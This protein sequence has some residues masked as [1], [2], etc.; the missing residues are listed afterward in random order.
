MQAE[1]VVDAGRPA[2]E[3]ADDDQVRQLRVA[4]AAAAEAALAVGRVALAGTRA[5]RLVGGVGTDSGGR[6][7]VLGLRHERASVTAMHV[8]RSR[9]QRQLI[10]QRR[11][12]LLRP[13]LRSPL[14]PLRDRARLPA[15][16]AAGRAPGPGATCCAPPTRTSGSPSCRSAPPTSPGRGST[17]WSRPT[18][19]TSPKSSWSNAR[20][21]TPPIRRSPPPSSCRR[22]STPPS[23][24]WSSSTRSARGCC[25]RCRELP[26][27]PAFEISFWATTR[28]RWRSRSALLLLAIAVGIYF[29]A[30]RVRRFW[31][32]VRQGLVILTQPRRYLREVAAWQGVGWLCR[33]AAFWFFL[34]AFGHR[35][36]RSAT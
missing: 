9:L 1:V 34:E 13:S 17:R 35:R 24:S 5:H 14:D 15:G 23:G 20:S 6:L 21:P 7:G 30:H 31:A 3:P 26:D 27:L 16:D 19:A 29:L 2:L 10:P 32:R 25:R 33:F 8:R 12:R 36:A 4:F 28:R 22:S 11:G 18:P